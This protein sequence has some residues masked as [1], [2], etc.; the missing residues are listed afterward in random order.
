MFFVILSVENSIYFIFLLSLI[1]RKESMVR[2]MD[3]FS[4][5][6]SIQQP[7]YRQS[8]LIKGIGDDAAVF[9]PQY[10]DLVTA[11]DMFVENVHFAKHTMHPYHIGYKALAANLSDLAAM[12][13]KPLFYLVGISI[14]DRWSSSEINEIFRGM[15]KIADTYKIDLIGGDTVSGKELV[16]SITVIGDT[17]KARYRSLAK[18]GDVI[19]V[20]GTLGDSQAGLHILNN[21]GIFRDE[22]YYMTRHQMPS[23]RVEFSQGLQKISRLALNDISDGIASE[24]NEIAEASKVSI[25]IYEDRLP[26]HPTFIQFDSELQNKWKLFGG[27]DFELLGAVPKHDWKNVQQVASQL[28]VPITKIGYVSS[29]NSVGQVFLQRKNEKLERLEKKGYNHLSR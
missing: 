16:I 28:K 29:R 8:S 22:D 5:I 10:Q 9:R 21:R 17:D 12:G 19:F 7:H 23:P 11:K 3:E 13:A 25:M 27:E 18:E 24:A 2:G 4:F 15:K 14:S 1:Y 6:G 20:T 26:V